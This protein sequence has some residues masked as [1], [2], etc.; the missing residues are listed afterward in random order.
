MK[1]SYLEGWWTDVST[2]DSLLRA[3]NQVAQLAGRKQSHIEV[4]G[5]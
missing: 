5:V 1:F 3:A 4:S 2:F